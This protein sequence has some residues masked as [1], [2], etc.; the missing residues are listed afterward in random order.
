MVAI[1]NLA[2]CYFIFKKVWL[3]YFFFSQILVF[4]VSFFNGLLDIIS[5]VRNIFY[6]LF[7]ISLHFLI[8]I[9]KF[10]FSEKYYTFCLTFKENKF[11]PWH[12]LRK[13]EKNKIFV[14]TIPKGVGNKKIGGAAWG[15][16]NVLTP[17]Q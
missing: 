17:K 1:E 5:L 11:P 15:V 8:N 3:Y 7:F 10:C 14:A 13:Q 12:V 6:R 16:R 2:E 9:W 4:F